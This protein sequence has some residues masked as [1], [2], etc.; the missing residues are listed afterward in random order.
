MANSLEARV[1]FLDDKLVSY[2]MSIPKIKSKV[3]WQ[4]NSEEIS[5]GDLAGRNNL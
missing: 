5:G 1:P 3:E 2:S 4:K